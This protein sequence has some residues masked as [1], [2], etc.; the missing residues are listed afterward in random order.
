[1]T[2]KWLS[3]YASVLLISSFATSSASAS[4]VKTGEGKNIRLAATQARQKPANDTADKNAKPFVNN[5]YVLTG[6]LPV[7]GYHKGTPV[8][9]VVD[10]G[11]HSTHVLQLQGQKIVRVMTVSNAIGSDDKPTPI[12][13]YTVWKKEMYPKWI[14]PKT[15]DPKQK[16]V[17][18]Y[19]QTHKNPL[20]VAAI[21][22][23]KFDIDLHGTNEPNMIRQDAS[24]GCV[25]H[26]NKDIMKLYGMIKQGDAVYIVNKFRGKVLQKSDFVRSNGAHHVA[27][28]STEAPKPIEQPAPTKKSRVSLVWYTVDT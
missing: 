3:A 21:Y 20:G 12:G 6:S 28:Q 15:I 11:S 8:V 7:N 18:P 13:R 27:D 24:H 2:N 5:H 16:P 17:A 10:K 9:V 22:L 19:N 25:R 1:M 4:S 26:S 23:N 14:P